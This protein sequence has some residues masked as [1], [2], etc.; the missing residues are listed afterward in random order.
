VTKNNGTLQADRQ[1][2]TIRLW[3][4]TVGWDLRKSAISPIADFGD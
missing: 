1:F 4:D 2:G 3:L